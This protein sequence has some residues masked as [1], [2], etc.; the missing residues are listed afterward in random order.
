[1]TLVDS[2]PF[3]ETMGCR[4]SSYIMISEFC[5]QRIRQTKRAMSGN[6]SKEESDKEL[7]DA[8]ANGDVRKV[9]ELLSQGGRVDAREQGFTP[10]LVAAQYGHTEVCELLL[11]NGSDL[12]ERE[13]KAQY[14]ALHSAAISNGVKPTGC[15]SFT[16][17][18][19]VSNSSLQT[20]VWPS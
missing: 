12:E 16:F 20:S 7:V 2:S 15:V 18:L 17:A 8:A 1:M 19:P 10:L 14:T 6:C 13:P 5:F 11:A 4:A 9:A 3:A